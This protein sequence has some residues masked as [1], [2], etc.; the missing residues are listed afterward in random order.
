MVG[1][2]REEE[3][4]EGMMSKAITKDEGGKNSSKG[5]EGMCE[6]TQGTQEVEAM[7]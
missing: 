6:S 2:G 4:V 7:R 5:G 1:D 3:E